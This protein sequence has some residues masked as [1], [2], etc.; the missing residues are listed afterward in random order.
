MTAGQRE[1]RFT[2]KYDFNIG[3]FCKLDRSDSREGDRNTALSQYFISNKEK[4]N[5]FSSQRSR[6][7]AEMTSW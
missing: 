2:V 4:K 7:P 3:L 6:Y 1:E 5:T